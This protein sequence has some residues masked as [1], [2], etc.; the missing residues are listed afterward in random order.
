MSRS[1]FALVLVSAAAFAAT[2]NPETLTE[3]SQD[4]ARAVLDRAVEANGGAE[5]LRAVNIVRVT[6]QGRDF[7]A[8]ADA[9]ADAALRGRPVRRDAAGRPQGQSP[10]PRAEGGRFRLRRRQHGHDRRRRGQQLRQSREDRHADS[11]RAGDAAAVRPV[12]PAAAEP[13]APRGARPHQL[14]ALPRRRR[15]RGPPPGR[16]DLRHAG[17]AAGRP[18]YRFND[19]PR[20]EVRAAHRRFADGRRGVRDHLQRLPEARELPGAAALDEPAG[21]R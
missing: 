7:P 21:R 15:L 9:D 4:K 1:A 10:A 19:R 3:R 13:A 12:P 20:I 17:H 6:A 11:G 8:T 14:A 2:D 16:A 18:L 5:A